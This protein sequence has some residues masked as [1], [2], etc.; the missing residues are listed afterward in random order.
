MQGK[1]FALVAAVLVAAGLAVVSRAADDGSTPSTQPS[2]EM[3]GVHRSRKIFEP[4]GMLTDLSDDQKMQ[5][6]KIHTDYLAQEKALREKQDSDVMALL[7]PDQKTEL[8]KAM[9]ESA[10]EK[11]EKAAARKKQ[12]MMEESTTMPSR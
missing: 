6:D 9:E 4:F 10:A 8:A 3:P 12:K 11:K 7:T 5:I 1:R 2:N